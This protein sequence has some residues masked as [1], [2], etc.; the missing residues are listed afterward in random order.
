MANKAYGAVSHIG[1]STGDLDKISEA[2]LSDGDVAFVIDATNDTV[3]VYT[4]N[5]SSAAAEDAV[6]FTVIVPDD[7]AA[8]PGKR[9]IK[10]DV[11]GW[12]G[13][14]HK[15]LSLAPQTNVATEWTA[16]QNFNET[17]LSDGASIAWDL[18]ANQVCN[19]TITAD[20][21]M[22]APTNNKQGRTYILRVIQDATGG[23]SLTWNAEFLWGPDGAPTLANAAN[24]VT[25]IAFY[26]DGTSLHGKVFYRES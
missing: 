17:S 19:V 3:D 26:D 14:T 18:D 2:V 12:D 9:W 24:D 21:T 22:A 4:L 16:G 23:H 10:V 8:S 11:R 13:T 20:R 15:K 25:V 5:S 7:E 1:G 6:N